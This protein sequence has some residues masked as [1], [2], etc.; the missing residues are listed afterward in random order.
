MSIQSKLENEKSLINESLHAIEK[1]LS[2]EKSKIRI[3]VNSF[4]SIIVSS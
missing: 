4:K 3:L 1:K 2:D